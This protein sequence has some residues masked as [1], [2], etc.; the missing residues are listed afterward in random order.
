[1]TD[2][3]VRIEGLGAWLT[4]GNADRVDLAGRFARDPRIDSWCDHRPD[5]QHHDVDQRVRRH[6]Q[7]RQR[8]S[9][10]G[11]TYTFTGVP[12]YDSPVLIAD[13]SVVGL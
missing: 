5:R 10:S 4:K 13:R 9:V 3:R 11:S 1:M 8:W 7:H 12:L 6:R 2:R